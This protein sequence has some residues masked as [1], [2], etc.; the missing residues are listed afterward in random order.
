MPKTLDAASDAASPPRAGVGGV[1]AGDD[2]DSAST[3]GR[4]G[5]QG[6]GGAGSGLARFLSHPLYTLVIALCALLLGNTKV[7]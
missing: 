1:S 2:A 4:H 5:R 3:R 7:W 6:G